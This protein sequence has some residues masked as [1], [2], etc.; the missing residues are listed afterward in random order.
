MLYFVAIIG[1]IATGIFAKPLTMTEF[2]TIAFS[3]SAWG[4]FAFILATASYSAGSMDKDSYSS[5]LMAVL[6][7]VVISPL[8]LRATLSI[9]SSVKEKYLNKARDA[10]DNQWHPVY[11]CIHTKGTGRWGHQDKLLHCIFELNLEIID[12]RAYNEAEY[13]YSHHL[14]IVQDV[15]YVLDKTLRLPPTKR[16]CKADERRLQNRYKTVK[17]SLRETMEDPHTSIDVM[18]WLPGVRR[19]DDVQ[20][21]AKLKHAQKRKSKT[22]TYCRKAAYRQARLALDNEL[23][24]SSTY[25]VSGISRIRPT[26]DAMHRNK[27]TYHGGIHTEQDDLLALTFIDTLTSLQYSLSPENRGSPIDAQD[28]EPLNAEEVFSKLNTLRSCVE[29]MEV[30]KPALSDDGRGSVRSAV[31]LT[32]NN[33]QRHNIRHAAGVVGEPSNTSIHSF[34]QYHATHMSAVANGANGASQM[35][36]F[37]PLGHP[38]LSAESSVQPYPLGLHTN[39]DTAAVVNINNADATVANGHDVHQAGQQQQHPINN[40]FEIKEEKQPQPQSLLLGAEHGS[41]GGITHTRSYRDLMSTLTTMNSA[42]SQLQSGVSGVN[43]IPKPGLFA[44]ASVPAAL[45]QHAHHGPYYHHHAHHHHSHGHKHIP[46]DTYPRDNFQHHPHQLSATHSSED[47]IQHSG[48]ESGSS[49]DNSDGQQCR[50]MYGDED[51]HHRPL[52]LYTN[53]DDLDEEEPDL[54]EKDAAAELNNKR[55]N[56]ETGNNKDNNAKNNKKH[57]QKKKRKEKNKKNGK[58]HSILSLPIS[59]RSQTGDADAEESLKRSTTWSKLHTIFRPKKLSDDE[60]EHSAHKPLTF[61]RQQGVPKAMSLP[62]EPQTISDDEVQRIE[63][64]EVSE[65]DAKKK[66]QLFSAF[67][68]STHKNGNKN[69]TTATHKK[70]PSQTFDSGQYNI[71]ELLNDEERETLPLKSADDNDD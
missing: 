16:L 57:N 20:S 68:K 10:D 60:S 33:V 41:I 49:S 37:I 22:V 7:S 8:C 23:A 13:N 24:R 39:G 65:R 31:G 56:S 55:R 62:G 25:L 2:F 29:Q 47:P 44:S 14:P 51:E 9:A 70:V 35:V 52:C 54:D 59:P 64:N 53:L 1:K 15:F 3:M 48:T 63:R 46:L 19:T 45:S 17:R 34:D 18:R 36:P 32:H 6:L 66:H 43:G 42:Q 12:F 30:F 50:T 11:F 21:P 27:F 40:T 69:N 5:V 67:K 71:D 4:E 38:N 58:A 26:H 61:K 28:K